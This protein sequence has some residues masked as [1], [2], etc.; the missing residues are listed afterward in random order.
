MRCPADW[1]KASWNKALVPQF[2]TSP[3]SLVTHPRALKSLNFPVSRLWR[4]KTFQTKHVDFY[5]RMC[6]K[7]AYL[8][9]TTY[10]KVRLRTI[11][12]WIQ[13]VWKLS[14][15]YKTNSKLLRR[16]TLS[17]LSGNPHCPDN[18]FNC[19]KTFQNV[20]KHC[21]LP[22]KFS[23]CT[24]TFQ[25]VWESSRLSRKFPDYPESFQTVWKLFHLFKLS[26][27]F[28]VCPETSQIV[29]KL[30]RLS[31]I[32]PK[33]CYV[34]YVFSANFVDTGKHILVSNAD[35]PMFFSGSAQ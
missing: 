34:V 20:L 21:Q 35:T 28:P 14:K 6:T 3:S 16:S 31:R 18:F 24:E 13:A 12:K 15:D 11:Y 29:Q 8:V 30:S 27:S 19:Q 5:P 23:D 1:A 22:R 9:Y 7:S 26:Q 33:L 17:R 32:F 2:S 4:A 25:T 10:T